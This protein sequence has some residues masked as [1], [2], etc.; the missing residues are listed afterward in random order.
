MVHFGLFCPPGS[1]HLNPIATL[2]HQLQHREHRVTL[3]NIGD[4]Q[5]VA[6]T[7]GI[8]FYPIGQAE[9][10]PGSAAQTQEKLGQLDGLIALKYT[11]GQAEVSVKQCHENLKSSCSGDFSDRG[12]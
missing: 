6:D 7:A 4:A 9:F 11:R 3:I 1:G 8:E 10:P 2:G 12:F 5:T